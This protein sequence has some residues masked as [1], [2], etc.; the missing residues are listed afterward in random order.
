VLSV[1]RE[2][3]KRITVGGERGRDRGYVLGLHTEEAEKISR[4]GGEGLFYP[5]SRNVVPLWRVNKGKQQN[6]RGRKDGSLV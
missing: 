3:L 4:Q 5:G 2:L 1:E 6:A